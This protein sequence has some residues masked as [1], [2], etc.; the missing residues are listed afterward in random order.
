MPTNLTHNHQSTRAEVL[1]DGLVQVVA[2]AEKVAASQQVHPTTLPVLP[3][4]S[5]VLFPGAIVPLTIGRDSSRRLLE[6]LPTE[7]GWVAVFTQKTAEKEEAGLDDLYHTGV[8]AQVL[9][10]VKNDDNVV[11]IVSARERIRGRAVVST[12]PYLTIEAEYLETKSHPD[13]ASWEAAVVSLRDSALKLLA[14]K[15]EIPDQVAGFIRDL[16]DGGKLADFV[17]G[18]LEVETIEKQA[19]LDELDPL[20][21]V[22]LSQRLVS[23]QLQIAT[24]SD[25]IQQDVQSQFTDAQRKAW[26]HE[27][28][29]AIQKELGEDEEV[30]KSALQ[31]W[32]DK[33]EAA[34]L[35][36]AALDQ[37]H[38]ELKRLE[39][40]PEG[41]PE[42]GVIS[43]YLETM[44]ALPWN[45][46]SED[47]LDLKRARRILDHD[48]HGLEK[49]KR[50]LLEHLAV[51]KLN[52]G[53]HSPILCLFGPPGVGKT[54]LGQS[55]ADALGRSFVRVSL[56]GVRDESDIR[57]HR[58]TYIGA[59]PGRLINEI[60]RAG[61]RNPVVLLDEVD[62]LGRD[63]RGDP[64]SALLEVLDPNQNH[65]FTDHYLD[66]PFDLSKV[67][68]IATAND[69]A[70]IPGPLR[71]R[72]EIVELT[73]Y[74][75]REKLAIATRYL[76]PRQRRDHGLKKAQ[77]VFKSEALRHVISHYTR[78]AGVRELERQIAALC[79]SVAARV[80]AEESDGAVI[81]R[82][83]VERELG[84]PKYLHDE[85][86]EAP[87][88]GIVT[89]LA[90]TSVGGELLHI[91]ALRFPG[92]GHVQLTGQLGD[93]MK[94]S[95]QAAWSLLRSRGATLGLS[96]EVFADQDVHVHV[97]AG[98]TPKDG[99]SAGVAMFTAL[100]SQ[101]TGRPVRPELAMTGEISLRGTVLP[102]GGL[103]EKLLAAV[104]A[105]LKTVLIPHDNEK[106]LV[107]VPAEA[108]S[109]LK[110]ISVRTV[111][112]VLAYALV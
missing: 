36:P 89:G 76:V 108:R 51:R 103:K 80:A 74:T 48:H 99:P 70:P 67:L 93:V 94:E 56:G 5:A 44:T 97:P 95:V 59:M 21:R 68:F 47:N 6:S 60:R 22:K 105:G 92:K 17:A 24:I 58:R 13:S 10:V 3:I 88:L 20:K 64:A 29:R 85:R 77:C 63:F 100:A 12:T 79:R 39:Y 78:E 1:G 71:D 90:W 37:A 106:D 43:T 35:P 9:R 18:G 84:P 8:A 62:K 102:I 54:S 98:A 33:V 30:G 53:G 19:V 46:E 112:E 87:R 109:K 75:E 7:N 34:A 50:R 57:G 16:V 52:P 86:L 82:A 104:R 2:Q 25:K 4:R 66:V 107:D 101:F 31:E 96:K 26:L 40:I 111:D 72:L 32:R 69:L 81:D 11:A 83:F 110:I 14:M 65:T 73:S 91:E 27:Q 38:R 45:A 28:M 55:I 61:T 15:N 42:F 49:V 23:K 41:S